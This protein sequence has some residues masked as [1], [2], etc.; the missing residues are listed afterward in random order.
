MDSVSFQ[1]ISDRIQAHVQE[2][3]WQNSPSR[4]LAISIVLEATELLEHYQWQV[5]PVGSKEDLASELADIFIYAFQLANNNQINIPEAIIKKLEKMA[6]KYPAKDF[7]GKDV[8]ERN[9]VWIEKKLKHKKS[10]L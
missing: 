9:L 8:K 2:R 1:Q 5:E 7:K 10:G 4:S 6:K 3:D